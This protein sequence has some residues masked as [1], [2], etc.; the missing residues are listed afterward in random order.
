MREE[1]RPSPKKSRF[2]WKIS[3]ILASLKS[4][5]QSLEFDGSGETGG[6]EWKVVFEKISEASSGIAYVIPPV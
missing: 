1:S 3:V 4:Q 2:V 6:I 5:D